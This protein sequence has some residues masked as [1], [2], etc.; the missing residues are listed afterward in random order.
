MFENDGWINMV[1]NCQNDPKHM[2][3]YMRYR[4]D[5]GGFTKK[6]FI[7]VCHKCGG[8]MV[9]IGR[10][11]YGN[12]GWQYQCENCGQLHHVRRSEE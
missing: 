3:K 10:A 9:K 11:R 2:I 4:G 8:R 7:P 6:K 12:F 1:R 5:F